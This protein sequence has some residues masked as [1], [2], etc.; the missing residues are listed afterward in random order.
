MHSAPYYQFEGKGKNNHGVINLRLP[1][2][3][4]GIIDVTAPGPPTLSDELSKKATAFSQTTTT[5]HYFVGVYFLEFTRHGGGKSWRGD[6][7]SLYATQVNIG[8]SS[9]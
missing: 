1:G 2:S 7:V 4:H 5:M 8:Y 3:F 6:S 9:E